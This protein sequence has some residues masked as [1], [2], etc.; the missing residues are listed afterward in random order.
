MGKSSSM[1]YFA[2]KWVKER[3]KGGECMQQNHSQHNNPNCCH[4][5]TSSINRTYLVSI[6]NKV[7]LKKGIKQQ[8]YIVFVF[9]NFHLTSSF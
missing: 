1:A 6:F 7:I 5:H 9:Q 3:K 8:K 2:M 4:W